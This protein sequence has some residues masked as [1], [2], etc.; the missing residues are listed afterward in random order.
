MLSCVWCCE[1]LCVI[2]L[3]CVVLCCTRVV[4]YSWCVVSRCVESHVLV[5]RRIGFV[6]CCLL[7]NRLKLL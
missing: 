5:L 2:V 4:L 6:M 3:L 1:V 7:L